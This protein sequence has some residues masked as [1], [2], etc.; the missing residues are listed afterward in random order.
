MGREDNYR[1]DDGV[2]IGPYQVQ[3]I[4]EFVGLSV[5]WLRKFMWNKERFEKELAP[6]FNGNPQDDYHNIALRESGWDP[7]LVS[8]RK[9]IQMAIEKCI[10]HTA[11]CILTGRIYYD[12]KE[13]FKLKVH[14]GSVNCKEVL[15][16]FLKKFDSF[17]L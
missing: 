5:T 4:R 15:Y 13:V 14:R 7:Y 10:E 11:M 3:T 12:A 6:F 17:Y 8:K 1:T 9:D 2:D 16:H